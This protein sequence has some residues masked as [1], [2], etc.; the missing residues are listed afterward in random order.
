M[1][2]IGERNERTISRPSVEYVPVEGGGIRYV[3]LVVEASYWAPKYKGKETLYLVKF[4]V[5]FETYKDLF[6]THW[7]SQENREP[8][9]VEDIHSL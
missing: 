3:R 5:L 9:R 2:V 4:S 7:M 6:T 1:G 8:C